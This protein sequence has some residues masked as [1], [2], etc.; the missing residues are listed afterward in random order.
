MRLLLFSLLIAANANAQ[1]DVQSSARVLAD[2]HFESSRDYITFDSALVRDES[3]SYLAT[4]GGLFR[5]PPRITAG[6][7]AELIGFSGRIVH[8]VALHDGVMYVLKEGSEN[9][10]GPASD[11]T[12]LRSSDR[13]ATFQPMDQRLEE[14]LGG[15]CSFLEAT[16][17][18][19]RDGAIIVNAGGNVLSTVDGGNSWTPLAGAI[20][21]MA[22]Y[23]PTLASIDDRLIIGG[24]CPLDVAYIRAGQLRSDGLGWTRAPESVVTPFL[25]N[26]NVQFIR[27]VRSSTTVIAGIE[28]AILRSADGGES[29]DF[30]FRQPIESSSYIYFTTFLAP[31]GSNRLLIG[32]FDKA[33]V[34]ATLWQSDDDGRSWRERTS[35]LRFDDHQFE[36]LVFLHEDADGRLLAGLLD[37]DAKLVRI[38]ELNLASDRRRPVRR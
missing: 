1:V 38:V 29:F 6:A 16:E 26:R 4:P 18:V 37:W 35:L 5:L 19:F 30:A 34:T 22:C 8:S 2:V 33:N 10:Q 17:I 3:S 32:G 11:H 31:S 36:S 9:A 12:I 27:Q 13:G 7:S 23:H 28:G 15:Y 21:Q 20:A 24:E 14:C 25:E